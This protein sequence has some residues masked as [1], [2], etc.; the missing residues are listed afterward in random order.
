M[1]RFEILDQSCHTRQAIELLGNKWTV[2][3]LHALSGGTRRYGQIKQ[4]VDGISHK[5]LAQTLRS[6]ERDGLIERYMYPEIPPKVEYRLSPLGRTLLPVLNQ[7]CDWAASH[8]TLVLEAR[9]GAD[10]LTTDVGEI[11]ESAAVAD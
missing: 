2:L 1:E 4:I 11:D 3:V 6:L 10:A 5:M 8:F 9:S 7:L